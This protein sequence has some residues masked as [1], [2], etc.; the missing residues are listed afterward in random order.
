MPMF[1]HPSD[2]SSR[3][4]CAAPTSL[5][6]ALALA[7]SMTLV[8]GACSSSESHKVVETPTVESYATDYGG[9]RYALS[10]GRFS[11]NSPYL[12]GIFSEGEDR[13]GDSEP[14][15]EQGLLAASHREAPDIVAPAQRLGDGDDAVPVGIG[16]EDGD[17]KRSLAREGLEDGDVVSDGVEI[18]LDP[19]LVH[20]DGVSD[21]AGRGKPKAARNVSPMR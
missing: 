21:P 17:N 1:A 10:I 14:A 3:G 20:Q 2:C 4:R 8:S 7:L 19:C 15:Q 5:L 16:L 9:P 12:R 18:D 6:V 13:L 11:N